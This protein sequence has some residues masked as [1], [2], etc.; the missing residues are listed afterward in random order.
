MRV[1][2]ALQSPMTG[3]HV[4]ISG[5]QQ[6]VQND[7]KF[8][9]DTGSFFSGHE[10]L[11]LDPALSELALQVNNAFIDAS[12]GSTRSESFYTRKAELVLVGQRVPSATQPDNHNI[13]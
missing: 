7:F 8:C 1:I 6:T 13:K 3:H 10:E 9:E 11:A 5:G 12:R 4:T 2:P